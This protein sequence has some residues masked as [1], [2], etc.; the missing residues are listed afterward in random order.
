MADYEYSVKKFFS[1]KYLLIYLVVAVVVYGL[2]YYFFFSKTAYQNRAQYV[3]YNQTVPT[4]K[5]WKIDLK[6]QN[7]SKIEGSA[8]LTE[9]DG[10]TKVVLA[11]AS[12]SAVAM[13]AHIHTGVCPNPGAVKYPLAAVVEGRSETIVSV[14]IDE[15]RKQLPL[16]INVHKSVVEPQS[17]VSCGDLK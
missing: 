8:L 5:Q 3:N 6:A 7:G 1:W 17:Y 12:S 15:L 11:L 2:V 9:A 14:T 13:P 16:A 10:K 4:P